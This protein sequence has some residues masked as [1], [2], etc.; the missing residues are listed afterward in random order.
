MGKR[1]YI[2]RTPGEKFRDNILLAYPEWSEWSRNLRRIFV[3]LPAYGVGDAALESMCDDFGWKYDKIC[4]MM[5]SVPSFVSAV[6]EYQANGYQYRTGKRQ[7]TSGT[8]PFTVKWAH[9]MQVYMMESGIA[10]FIKGEVGKLSGP[11]QKLIEKAGLLEV[12]SVVHQRDTGAEDAGKK[13]MQYSNEGE[14]AIFTLAE[15]LS[16]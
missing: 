7:V 13:G 10:A 3:C 5:A 12:E 4:K 6:D 14:S 1:S 8:L 9:L 15:D 11:E 16:A 2:A